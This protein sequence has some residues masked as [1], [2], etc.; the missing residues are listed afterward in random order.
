[1]KAE[2]GLIEKKNIVSKK[3]NKDLK[4]YTRSLK[5]KNKNLVD[6]ETLNLSIRQKIDSKM[7]NSYYKSEF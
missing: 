4:P 6:D 2:V 7:S 1:M 5:D 3:I